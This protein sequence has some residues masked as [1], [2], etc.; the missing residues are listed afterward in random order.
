VAKEPKPT[1]T[2][3]S[4]SDAARDFRVGCLFLVGIVI[5]LWILLWIAWTFWPAH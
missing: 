5:A 4:G 2:P 1:R 3:D